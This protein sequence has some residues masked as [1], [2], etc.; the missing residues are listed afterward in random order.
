MKAADISD[1]EMLSI[2]QKVALPH[3]ATMLLDAQKAMPQ[4]PPKI[5]LAKFRSM[6]KRGIIEG[7]PC[8]CR[9]DFKEIT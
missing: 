2:M 6:I 7:C 9:G 4:Y 5:V 1:E 8:G 3:G